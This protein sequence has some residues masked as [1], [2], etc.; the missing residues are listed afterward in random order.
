MGLAL[1]ADAGNV[2]TLVGMGVW[3]MPEQRRILEH[4]NI[5]GKSEQESPRERG[6]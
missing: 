2:L 4:L 1:D 5:V 3:G 6:T